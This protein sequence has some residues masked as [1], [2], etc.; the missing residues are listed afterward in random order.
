MW[1]FQ[2]DENPEP[3]GGLKIHHWKNG[4]HSAEHA[5]VGYLTAQALRSQPAT[6][7]FATPAGAPLR[8]YLFAGKAKV[9]ATRPL[10]GLPGRRAR[11]VAFTGLH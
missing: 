11:Q 1:G 3:A 7:W 9:L 5:L 2:A 8:P 6:L 4:Y 10:P